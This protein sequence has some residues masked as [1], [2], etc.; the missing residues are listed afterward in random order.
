MPP[1]DVLG[2]ELLVADH[3]EEEPP[4]E[5]LDARAAMHELVCED[6]AGV[7][8]SRAGKDDD[9]EEVRE[10]RAGTG[11]GP[12]VEL[13]RHDAHE[14]VVQELKTDEQVELHLER[15]LRQ[16]LGRLAVIGRR[17]VVDEH[18]RHDG[19]R[20]EQG[21]PPDVRPRQQEREVHER[22]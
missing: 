6:D 18:Q 2:R 1:A 5:E 13:R 4:E 7:A 3:D 12:D 21:A 10:R 20:P 17:A 15:E 16:R 22:E 14:D 9:R 8:R 19:H 11:E